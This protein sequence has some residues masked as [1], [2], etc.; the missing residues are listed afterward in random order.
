[1]TVSAD[2]EN[3]AGAASDDSPA[4]FE[5]DIADFYETLLVPATVRSPA[6]RTIPTIVILFYNHS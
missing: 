2:I 1:V 5:E 3:G 6:N 4:P